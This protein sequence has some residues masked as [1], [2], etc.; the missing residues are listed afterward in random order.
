MNK[1]AILAHG[2]W[3]VSVLQ[4]KRRRHKGKS[5]RLGQH[6][7]SPQRPREIHLSQDSPHTNML[8]G[9]GLISKHEESVLLCVIAWLLSPQ[10]QAGWGTHK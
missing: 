7:I 2:Q 3:L 8:L 1:E 9:C 4:N 5:S 6:L 10:R